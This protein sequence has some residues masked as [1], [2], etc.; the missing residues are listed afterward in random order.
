MDTFVRFMILIGV[1]TAL[2]AAQVPSAER[3]HDQSAGGY[4]KA[5]AIAAPASL[6]RSTA[7]D[8]RPVALMSPLSTTIASGPVQLG[9]GDL[10][11]IGVFDA[12]ELT[13]RTRVNSDGAISF[14]LLGSLK[15]DGSTPEQLQ[16][17]I[18]SELKRR[19]LVKS[20]QVTVFIAE[21]ANQAVF[22]LGEVNRPGAYP[23]MGSHRLFDL[24]SAA[25]GF[26]ARA[27]RSIT[28]TRR[29]ATTPEIIRMGRDPDFAAGNPEV[30]AG[31]TIYVAQAGLVYVVG[32]VAHPG[33]F[34]IDAGEKLTLLQALAL[35]QGVQS[36]ASLKGTRLVRTTEHG[37]QEI[38]VDLKK[39][40]A[41]QVPDPTLQDQ[42][43][44]YVP[45]SASRTGFRRGIEAAL[46]AVVGVAIYRR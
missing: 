33:G 37:R 14:P 8:N 3:A 10:L 29:G 20:P 6:L 41:L 39:V 19:D 22:V 24:V 4:S 31:D 26:S 34:L 35:A 7:P 25:G 13:T 36:T 1:L 30:H 28:I 16:A 9:P 44:I 18:E 12:P 15:V 43:I 38:A 40:L 46:Q 23:V 32:D 11:E 42:D 5:Q 27:G 2:S 45:N 21:Y 17:L